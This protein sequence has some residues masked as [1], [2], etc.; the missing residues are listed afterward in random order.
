MSA[1]VRHEDVLPP[2]SSLDELA[3]TP[4]LAAS[5][6]PGCSPERDPIAEI[7]TVR[8]CEEHRP[9]DGGS[10]DERATV[11]TDILSSTGDAEAATNRR[12]CELL[13]RTRRR[14]SKEDIMHALWFLVFVVAL[15]GCAGQPAATSASAPVPSA[16]AASAPAA[17]QPA[18][19]PVAASAPTPAPAPEVSTASIAPP[20]EFVTLEALKDVHFGSARVDVLRADTRILDV[21]IGWLKERPSS[22]VLIEGYTDDLGT[23]AQNLILS[24][25]RAKSIMKYLVS[26]GVETERITVA[27]YGADRPV[28]TMKTEA[29]RAQNRRARLLVKER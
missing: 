16:P 7:L 14:S 21:L 12:W 3:D 15:W 13:H 24:E 11:S 2:A 1:R 23:R 20:N 9:R 17:E 8:W 25:K 26:R 10:D 4:N 18:A 27:S 19:P 28:C 29:C 22:L 5:Y 6:C